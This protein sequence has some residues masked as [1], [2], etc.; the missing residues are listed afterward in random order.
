MYAGSLEYAVTTTIL[1]L[2]TGLL[3]YI[4][5]IH[6]VGTTASHLVPVQL[7]GNCTICASLYVCSGMPRKCLF[8]TKKRATGSVGKSGSAA[9]ASVSSPEAKKRRFVF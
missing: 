9:D 5:H 4:I 1:Q 8:N 3:Q 7:P 6:G 2:Q